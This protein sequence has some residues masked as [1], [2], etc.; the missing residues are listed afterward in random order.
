MRQKQGFL[1]NAGPSMMI[2]VLLRGEELLAV[3]IAKELEERSESHLS[4]Q[5]STL[6]P[7]L[8]Q[9][10]KQGNVQSRWD[11]SDNE[12]PKRMYSL[13]DKG[14]REAELLIDSWMRHAEAVQRV[15]QRSPSRV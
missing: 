13:T 4:F 7:L 9:L 10:E 1:I 5:P 6:Y 8:H 3:D 12:R 11:L 2:L 14:Q 15:I